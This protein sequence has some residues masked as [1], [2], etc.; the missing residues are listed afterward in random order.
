[1]AW[2]RSANGDRDNGRN[3]ERLVP[4]LKRISRPLESP[5][6]LDPLVEAIGDARFVL[7]G[8]ASHGT[9]EFYTWHRRRG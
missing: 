5:R 2:G 9:S 7:M 6:D 3:A 4:G 8:E 1:M